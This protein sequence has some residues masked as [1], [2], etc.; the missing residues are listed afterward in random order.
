MKKKIFRWIKVILIVYAVTGIALYY[1]QDKLLL[2]PVAIDADSSFHFTQP[3]KEH[4]IVLDSTTRFH[5]VQ[6][7]VP[8]STKKGLVLYFHGNRENINHYAAYAQ[9]FTRNGYEVWMPDYPGF[10]KSTGKLTEKVLYEEAL[11]V[12]KMARAKY[13]PQQIIVYGKSFGTGVATQLASVR[14]CQK[15]ILE[16]PYYS[17]SSLLRPYFF[18]YPLDM[19]LHFRLPTH[20]YLAKVTAPV[21]II[22]GTH[23]RVISYRNASRLKPL[24]KP[25]D[26]F[27]TVQNGEH[28]GLGNFTLVQ[29]KIDSLLT[30]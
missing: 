14:D 15:L 30:R 18:M 10:G 6:F 1:L 16:T 28:N 13:Q 26:V 22:H 23:D 19:L 11:Q 3:F 4:T 27:I 12:Y 9:W 29:Q 8:D 25:G 17:A 24:L 7:T 21:T 20:E 5:M 2:R